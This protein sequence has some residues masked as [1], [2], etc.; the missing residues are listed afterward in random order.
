VFNAYGPGQHM[1]ASNPPVIPNFIHQAVRGGTLV[2]HSSGQQTRDYVYV[3][4]VVDAMVAAATASNIDRQTINVGSGSETSVRDLARLIIELTNSKAETV[5]TP[6]SD[7]GVSRMR[8]DL[9]RAKQLLGYS[10]NILLQDGLRLTLER[11][12]RFKRKG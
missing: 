9:S 4:D 1:P 2:V 6:R 7:P 12:P 11:D 3:E 5:F 10:P 8:A